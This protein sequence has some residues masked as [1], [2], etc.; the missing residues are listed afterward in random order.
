MGEKLNE[1]VSGL[2]QRI[3]ELTEQVRSLSATV[4]ALGLRVHGMPRQQPA[5]AP[6]LFA[7]D[8]D[9]SLAVASV[10]R[11][12]GST[13]LSSTAA[14]CFLLVIA[15]ILRMVSDIGV[16]NYEFGAFLG[17]VYAFALFVFAHVRYRRARRVVPVYSTCA[18]ILVFAIV[19]ENHARFVAI[20]PHLSYIILAIGSLVM[21]MLGLVHTIPTLIGMGTIGVAAIAVAAGFPEPLFPIAAALIL[22]TN[23]I[24][25][26][27]TRLVRC[28]W[29]GGGVLTVTIF[30]WFTWTIK[31]ITAFRHG[32]AQSP[33]V[34]ASW[35]LPVLAVFVAW[36]LFLAVRNALRSGDAIHGFET[37]LPIITV[38]WTYPVARSVVGSGGITRAS[39][40]IVAALLAAGLV[41]F[42]LSAAKRKGTL[43]R[44]LTAFIVGALLLCAVALPHL[45]GS[46]SAAVLLWSLIAL[47]LARLSWMWR[48]GTLRI[49]SYL[50]QTYACGV[51][52]NSVGILTLESWSIWRLVVPVAVSA[53]CLYHYAWCRSRP[54]KEHGEFFDTIDLGDRTAIMPFL[55]GVVCAFAALRMVWYESS[56][57]FGNGGAFQ[58][59]QSV[60]INAAA[61]LL[62]TLGLLR[63]NA[64]FLV[65]AAAIAILGA[66]KVFVYDF[67][68]I[69]HLPL[70]ISV[71][72]FGVTAALGALIWTKWQGVET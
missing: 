11:F 57:L 19:L 3:D 24:V 53:V 45:V 10:R 64:E 9:E 56:F 14:V 7:E 16:I 34:A 59:G 20:S 36:Y 54:P 13:F 28:G 58:S 40:G 5:A 22:M 32:E 35:F 62:A 52:L 23:I 70:V 61:I 25:C 39:L 48:S 4:E 49:F 26:A 65:V 8:P 63:K 50:L 29:M 68:H 6:A 43:T 18:G 67:F 46:M 71:F 21:V 51:A 33:T 69:Q 31:L 15:L 27:R 66:G 42:A 72:S 38:A 30:F 37:A 60:I 44:E 55:V 1:V 12:Q 17:L 47:F 2:R 41:I